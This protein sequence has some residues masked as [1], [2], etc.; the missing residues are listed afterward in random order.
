MAQ[1]W[2]K[3]EMAFKWLSEGAKASLLPEYGKY[4]QPWSRA[5]LAELARGLKDVVDLSVGTSKAYDHPPAHVLEAVK[6]ALDV[7]A[8]DTSTGHKAASELKEAI[9]ARYR[10]K[11]GIEVNPQSEVCLTVGAAQVIDSTLRIL[12]NPG[13]EVIMI[14][15]DYG[16]YEPHVRFHQARVVRV[17]LD[18]KKPGEWSFDPEQLRRRVTKKT[19]L[20]MMS[21]AN[22]P[23]GIL[24]TKEQNEAIAE[25]AMKKDFFVLAD[26]VSE[27]I[28]FDGL[29]LHNIASV[30]GMQERTIVCSSFSKAHCLHGFRIGYGIAN[31]TI[32]RH[33][34]SVV[35]WTTDGIVT[36]GVVAA[37]AA[38]KGPQDWVREH[39]RS[40]QKRRDM[41]VDRL[42]KM[43]GVACGRPQGIY[44][45][46]PN[47]KALGMPSH[48]LA[49]YLLV[50]GKVN[51]RPGMW[52]GRNGE[53][54]LRLAFCVDPEWIETAM[55]RMD[56]AVK[57][58]K[59]RR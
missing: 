46:F 13:D 9:A 34:S 1:E 47:I 56:E 6:K 26:H 48:D 31:K 22:N 8:F 25:L 21:N 11:Y 57:K 5:R 58:L 10:N 20:L 33:M 38:L 39:G 7:D 49:E 24:Y 15:P 17:P 18:E 43:D 16:P 55:D 19:K 2:T 52:Y 36:P 53:G 4:T 27:E 44:W 23:A 14:D 30:L 28:V 51:T 12:V 3:K 37:L 41:M 59:A 32:I 29:T 45:T 42:N 40:L 54:H 35:G 50:D